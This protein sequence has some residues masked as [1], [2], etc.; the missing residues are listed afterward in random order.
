[1]GQRHGEGG[2]TWTLADVQVGDNLIAVKMAGYDNEAGSDQ[3]CQQALA[4]R[5]NVV[6]KT[7]A[8]QDISRSYTGNPVFTD[9]SMT[10][11][12]GER[13]ANIMLNHVAQP[14]ATPS[15]N[16]P[17]LTVDAQGFVGRSARCDPRHS[18]VALIRTAQSLAVVCQTTPGS[19]YYHGERLSDGANVKLPNVVGS[20]N[21]FDVINPADGT[22][23]KVRPD[24]LTIISNGYADSEQALQYASG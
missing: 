18:L 9:A 6:V 10:G 13:L 17:G 24:Q 7:R 8:C 5:A 21:G 16:S 4:V 11:D 20:S 2:Y 23:Y 14:P 22:R 3:V 1:M 15:S 19:F 12:Y